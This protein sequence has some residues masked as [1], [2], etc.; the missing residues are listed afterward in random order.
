MLSYLGAAVLAVAALTSCVK[1]EYYPSEPTIADVA[2]SP[3]TVPAETAVTVT[4][5]ITDIQ[6]IA[7]AT[8]KYKV[9]GGSVQSAKMTANGKVYT[10]TIPAQ[11]NLSSVEFYVEAVNTVGAITA[12]AATTFQVGKIN[13]TLKL[14]EING[15]GADADKYIELINTGAESFSLEGVVVEYCGAVTWTGASGK[16]IAANGYFVIQGK[17][18]DMS[19][20]LS[21]GK[22]ITVTVK[23]PDGNVLDSFVRGTGDGSTAATPSD[24]SFSR[25]PDATGA[26]YLTDAAGTKGATNG[27]SA[28]GLLKVDFSVILNEINGALS[29]AADKYVELYNGSAATVSL[30]GWTISYNGTVAWTGKAGQT[31][32]AASYFVLLGTKVAGDTSLSTGLSAGKNIVLTLKNASGETVD[33][34]VR[35]TGDGSDIT[36]GTTGKSYSRVPNG[37]GKWYFTDPAGTRGATNGTDTTGLTLTD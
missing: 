9:N 14:N 34:F 2:F 26:W 32:A 24:K 11:A 5:T 25:I 10:G 12:S 21:A 17:G 15:T 7:S 18:V 19:K 20:G 36:S 22:D 27:T 30:E 13:Y 33:E 8:I 29:A 4:A 16:T 3:L 37:Y 28:S 6:G 1:D 35:G 23:D 31:V